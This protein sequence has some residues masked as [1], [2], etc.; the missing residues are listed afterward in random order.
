[1]PTSYRKDKNNGSYVSSVP[2]LLQ[3]TGTPDFILYSAVVSGLRFH[4]RVR[5][6]KTINIHV[7]RQIWPSSRQWSVVTSLLPSHSPIIFLQTV[8][9]NFI[10]ISIFNIVLLFLLQ[11]AA[12]DCFGTLESIPGRNAHSRWEHRRN[13]ETFCKLFYPHA[14][15]FWHLDTW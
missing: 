15:C 9:L 11:L 2:S 5:P 7:L 3:C 13:F 6:T 12:G 8:C 14:A 1:M 10:Q 4:I